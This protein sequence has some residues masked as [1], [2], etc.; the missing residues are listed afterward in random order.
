VIGAVILVISGALFL[1]VLIRG[2]RTPQADSGP[3]R[4]S[5]ALHPPTSLPAVL[6]SHGLWIALMI[7]LTITNY[8]FP[9]LNLAARSDTSVPAVYVGAQ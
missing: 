1:T 9:I 2:Q 8:G 3:Y 4:F 6:N 7:A 5:V